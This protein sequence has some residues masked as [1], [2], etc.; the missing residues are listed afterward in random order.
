M[1]KNGK[2]ITFELTNQFQAGYFSDHLKEFAGYYS[3]RSVTKT[4]KN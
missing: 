2:S 4:M 3:N 1:A